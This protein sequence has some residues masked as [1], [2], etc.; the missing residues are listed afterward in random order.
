MKK[1]KLKIYQPKIKGC[2]D[3]FFYEGLIAKKG[4][5]ELHAIGDIRIY[6]FDEKGHELGMYDGKCRDGFPEIKN[7][8]DLAKTQNSPLFSW[9]MNNWFE[10]LN[11]S[12][13]FGDVYYSYDEAMVELQ[14]LIIKGIK[15]K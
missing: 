12:G 7:D 11:S 5:Y 2:D 6:Q 15:E 9:D 3:S 10:I 14:K 1:E 8:K 13:D 4:K